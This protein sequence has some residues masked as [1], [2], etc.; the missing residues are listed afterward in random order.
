MLG[1]NSGHCDALQAPVPGEGLRSDLLALCFDL[2]H[3]LRFSGA[4]VEA[5]V[6]GDLLVWG[7]AGFNLGVEPGQLMVVAVWCGVS[8]L[9]AR[10]SGYRTVVVKGGS[11]A[12]IVWTVQRMAFSG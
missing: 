5:G 1:R 12:L 10:W 8:P 2:V 4:L 3:W 9:L 7:L 11:V 6:S